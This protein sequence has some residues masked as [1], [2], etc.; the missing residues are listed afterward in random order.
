MLFVTEPLQS[1]GDGQ[2]NGRQP[3]R[4]RSRWSK[5]DNRR[6]AGLHPRLLARHVFYPVLRPHHVLQL[7]MS[8]TSICSEQFGELLFR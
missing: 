4:N 7:M 8:S 1:L 5:I 2:A 6:R 3:R